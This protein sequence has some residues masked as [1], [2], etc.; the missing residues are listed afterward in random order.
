M[1]S[2]QVPQARQALVHARAALTLQVSTPLSAPPCQATPLMNHT[3]SNSSSTM[4][5]LRR[6]PKPFLMQTPYVQTSCISVSMHPD[7]AGHQT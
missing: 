5:P 6:L 3:Y 4:C 7:L 2:A 1:L